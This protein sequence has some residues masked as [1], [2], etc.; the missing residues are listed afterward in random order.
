MCGKVGFGQLFGDKKSHIKWYHIY[1]NKRE[2][3]PLLFAI[4]QDL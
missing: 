4:D 2:F 1:L 3:F